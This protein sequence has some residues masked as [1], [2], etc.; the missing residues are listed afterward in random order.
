MW[1]A[2]WWGFAGLLLGV[3]LAGPMG[4]A[5]GAVVG[6]VVGSVAGAL[7][8]HHHRVAVMCGEQKSGGVPVRAIVAVAAC[9]VG[10]YVLA[11]AAVLVAVVAGAAVVIVAGLAVASRLLRDRL[12]V[13]HWPSMQAPDI[14][15]PVPVTV[16]ALPA[17]PLAIE[18]P[19]PAPAWDNGTPTGGVRVAVQERAAAADDVDD[20]PGV[21]RAGGASGSAPPRRVARLAG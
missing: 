5:L 3:V 14:P 9:A 11:Q 1:K 12:S 16:R 18:A 20:L 17:A 6:T 7:H 10:V 4:A 15:A 2:I 8:F 13:V 21:L 19:R